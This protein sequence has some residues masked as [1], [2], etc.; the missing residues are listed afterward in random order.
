MTEAATMSNLI[1]I[2]SLVSEIWLTTERNTD[3]HTDTNTDTDIDTQTDLS[4]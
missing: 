3:T 1:A 2:T 4:H